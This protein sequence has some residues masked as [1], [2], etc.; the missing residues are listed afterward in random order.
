MLDIKN[1][2]KKKPGISVSVFTNITDAVLGEKYDASLV[3]VGDTRSQS[4]N[5]KYRNKSY[6][7][8][9]LSFPL[10]KENGE[11]FINLKQA[12]KE[13]KEHGVPY[14]KYVGLLF[15]HGCLHLKGLDHG[16]KMDGLED[17]YLKKF[18]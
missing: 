11:I 9:V 14:K 1:Y 2:T 8:N 18:F 17:K 10:D 13:S 7:P 12:E 5:K 16:K 4:L 15:I 6:I 3:F